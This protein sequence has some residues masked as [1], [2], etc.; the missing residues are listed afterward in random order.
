MTDDGFHYTIREGIF[1]PYEL[2]RLTEDI[3]KIVIFV[4]QQETG[5][6]RI[7]RKIDKILEVLTDNR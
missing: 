2:K 5:L 6:E 3:S 1:S 7:E 4:P